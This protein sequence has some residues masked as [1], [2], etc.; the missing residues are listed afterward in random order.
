MSTEETMQQLH[1]AVAS[2]SVTAQRSAADHNEIISKLEEIELTKTD[3]VHWQCYTDQGW[4]D[5]DA[6]VTAQLE[7]AHKESSVVAFE[8]DGTKYT[9]DTATNEQRRS[10]TP[11]TKRAMRR[12]SVSETT[13]QNSHAIAMI[14]TVKDFTKHQAESNNRLLTDLRHRLTVLESLDKPQY[15]WECKAETGW[16]AYS[17]NI[18]DTIEAR[19]QVSAHLCCERAVKPHLTFVYCTECFL[20]ILRT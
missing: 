2:L 18:N 3:V 4:Q 10:T 7:S 15:A 11:F 9:A 12:V 20:S 17:T 14:Q 5:Y 13:L 6:K 16:V 8:V 1:S 19:Y